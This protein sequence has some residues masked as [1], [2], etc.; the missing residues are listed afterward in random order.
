MEHFLKAVVHCHDSGYSELLC[1]LVMLLFPFGLESW[2]MVKC[3]SESYRESTTSMVDQ[4]FCNIMAF[5][6]R[7]LLTDTLAS[8]KL[9]MK[10]K[11]R[12][13]ESHQKGF[14]E[15]T[16]QCPSTNTKESNNRLLNVSN[17]TS[18][19]GQNSENIES[20]HKSD[21]DSQECSNAQSVSGLDFASTKRHAERE[22]NS[23]PDEKQQES[24][25]KEIH[26][27]ALVCSTVLLSD[28]HAQLQ[29]FNGNIKTYVSEGG[30]VQDGCS[31]EKTEKEISLSVCIQE[32]F[33]L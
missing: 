13:E 12:L 7:A 24:S 8:Q 23:T 30:Y 18:N 2:Y 28:I 3:L 25:F 26:R 10:Q 19:E 17:V 20:L 9:K 1:H 16:V 14:S 5:Y 33:G 29:T 4:Y 21:E 22:D 11:Y 27:I 6:Y 31:A 15:D 32:L